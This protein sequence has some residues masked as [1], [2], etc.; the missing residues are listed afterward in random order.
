[1]INIKNLTILRDYLA[2]NQ[3]ELEPHFGMVS[4]VGTTSS[5]SSGISIGVACHLIP[6]V[7]G[8]SACVLGHAAMCGIPEI[9]ATDDD[10]YWNDYGLRVFGIGPSSC[11]VAD[12]IFHSDWARIDDTLEGAI[13]RITYVIDS[14]GKVP[15]NWTEDDL[16]EQDDD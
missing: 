13:D 2:A 6:T 4:W 3:A 16:Y 10:V 15:N 9:C 8:T 5:G 1:M 11:A 12:Y 7:C 14:N